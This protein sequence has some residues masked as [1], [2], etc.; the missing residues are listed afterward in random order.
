MS[1]SLDRQQRFLA[2]LREHQP[3]LDRY[4]LAM[5]RD[6]ETAKDV[7][8]ETLLIAFE[9]FDTLRNEQAFLSFLFTIATRTYRRAEARS[10]RHPRAG[11]H[12][13]GQMLD[14]GISPETAADI[15]A[16]HRAL[17]LLPEKQ[18]EAVVL[19][20]ILGLSMKEIQEIQGGTLIAVK[21]RIS[22]GRAKL[23]KHLGVEQTP[24]AGT[25][26]GRTERESARVNMHDLSFLSLGEKP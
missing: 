20:E 24:H 1:P 2:L 8:G 6:L 13:I 19:F 16:V 26:A 5:T 3:A 18:R 10:V 12:A 7:V 25:G 21:V 15:G 17:A 9:Q 4:V 22:R 14:P 11:E 23:A